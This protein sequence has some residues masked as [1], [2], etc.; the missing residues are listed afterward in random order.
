M[1]NENSK[2]I[3]L[4]KEIPEEVLESLKTL[5]KAEFNAYLVGGCVRDL[6]LNKTPKDWDIATNAKPEEIQKIFPE[7]FYENEFGTVGIVTQ[8]ENPTLKVIEITPYR[9][10]AKY[11]DKRH[12]DGVSFAATLEEDLS[13][14]DF[15]INALALKVKKQKSKSK[16]YEIIETERE[17]L[18]PI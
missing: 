16:N 3:N 7:T 1:A 4:N 6:L 15:T 12:P 8:S 2:E 10:E 5:E 11:S 18:E 9:K 13:R 14:R 17:K